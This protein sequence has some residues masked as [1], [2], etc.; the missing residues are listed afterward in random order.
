VSVLDPKIESL[1]KLRAWGLVDEDDSG[2]PHNP[3]Y[4]DGTSFDPQKI[5]DSKLVAFDECA[6]LLGQTSP[7]RRTYMATHAFVQLPPE[8]FFWAAPYELS[9]SQPFRDRLDT[10]DLTNCALA[11]EKRDWSVAMLFEL[12]PGEPL[13][14][15]RK[16]Q[17]QGELSVLVNP[18]RRLTLNFD[19]EDER[20]GLVRTITLAENDAL[21]EFVKT[22]EIKATPKPKYEPQAESEPSEADNAIGGQEIPDHIRELLRG[23]FP[24]VVRRVPEC[25]DYGIIDPWCICFPFTGRYQGKPISPAFN[26][27][28]QLVRLKDNHGVRRWFRTWQLLVNARKS[29]RYLKLEE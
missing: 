1:K 5:D 18:W 3:R 27:G 22:L 21:V 23:D 8:F 12:A 4:V 14:E 6:P 15:Y 24:G 17:T 10:C 26:L 11:K 28:K 25:D 2:N 7:E 29:K 20:H 9:D 19:L 16:I 13:P